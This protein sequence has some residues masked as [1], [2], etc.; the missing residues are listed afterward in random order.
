VHFT[1]L[2]RMSDFEVINFH[3][4]G[5][6]TNAG[7]SDDFFRVDQRQWQFRPAVALALG[8]PESDVTLG[9]VL[10]YSTT[11]TRPDRF[12]TEEQP[13]GVGDFGQAGVR[14]GLRYDARDRTR[15]ATRGFLIDMSSSAFP[16]VWD[17]TSAFSQLSG[18]AAT[19]LEL[20]L[21]HHPV[22]ALRGGGRKIWGDA[23][24]HEAAF[25]GG[26]DTL[27][28]VDPQRYAG[29]ASIFGNSELR[30]PVASIRTLLPLDIGILG[31]A[32]TGRVYVDGDSPSGWHTV[33]G[34]G[35]WVGILDP[36]TGVSVL[37]TNARDKRV[38]VG[39]GLRF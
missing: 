15:G 19:Y 3:G 26:V 38:V 25:L 5:N 7:P 9:P 13:Y 34:G 36:A 8:R 37:L 39:T 2:G 10:Q 23:P 12:V 31:F 35:L 30:I 18:S 28:G 24:F 27:T 6:D 14:A 32:D 16:A 4:Y 21:P 29:D 20:P 17:V 11:A 33:A 22:L 1:A